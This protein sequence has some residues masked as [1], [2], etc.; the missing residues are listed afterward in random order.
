MCSANVKDLSDDAL[1]RK[2]VG[3]SN[4]NEHAKAVDLF[5]EIVL[6]QPM[7]SAAHNNLA[8]G[9]T[10][11]GNS[12]EGKDWRV[13]YQ[14]AA[15]EA[16]IAQILDPDFELGRST[17]KMTIQNSWYRL[18]KLI[19]DEEKRWTEAR[20][21]VAAAFIGGEGSDASDFLSYGIEGKSTDTETTKL[22]EEEASSDA[23]IIDPELWD[24]LVSKSLDGYYNAMYDYGI[25]TL[26]MLFDVDRSD[27]D[28]IGMSSEDRDL[29]RS[30]LSDL[31]NAPEL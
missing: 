3:A 10:R 2:A 13:S 28:A 27:M 21:I 20:R 1:F 9:L 11:L 31:E 12:G 5:R 29:L 17:L 15:R 26:E 18:N 22:D 7:N 8:V 30:S 24:F 4:D 6:R 25:D 19:P 14:E 23:P 16:T